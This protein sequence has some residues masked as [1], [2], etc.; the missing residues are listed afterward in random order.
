MLMRCQCLFQVR[1][2]FLFI[3]MELFAD[4]AQ[5]PPQKGPGREHVKLV[6]L[7]KYKG[8][9]SDLRPF[10]YLFKIDAL[11][12]PFPLEIFPQGELLF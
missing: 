9:G 7:E 4:N 1:Q 5:E 6:F 12:F 10:L 11:D 3:E 2:E 8:L